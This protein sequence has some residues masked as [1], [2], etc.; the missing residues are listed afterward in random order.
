[1]VKTIVI[2]Q[3]EDGNNTYYI[4]DYVRVHMLP[5]NP[6]KP[7]LASKYIGRIID[8]TKDTFILNSLE[9]VVIIVSN[10][11]KMRLAEF[12][13]DFDNTPNF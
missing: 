3:I 5:R 1:M 2:K 11:D 6:N 7:Q 13:E 9:D 12:K 4:G 10:I 8:I